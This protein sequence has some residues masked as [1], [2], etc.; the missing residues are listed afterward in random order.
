[1]DGGTCEVCS[2]LNHTVCHDFVLPAS[3][4]IART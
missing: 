1:V 3:P 2:E 4:I